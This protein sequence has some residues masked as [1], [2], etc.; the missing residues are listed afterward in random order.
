MS[1]K[2]RVLETLNEI[3]DEASFK[4]IIYNLYMQYEVS[5][6]MQDIKNGNTYTSDEIKEMINKW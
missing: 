6:G 3:S 4:E 2:Q 5:K 1:D